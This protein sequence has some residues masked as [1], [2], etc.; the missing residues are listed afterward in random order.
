VQNPTI[1]HSRRWAILCVVAIAQL[2]VVLDAT[3]VNVALPSAQQALQFGDDDRQWVITAYTLA[4]GSVLLLGGKIGDLFGRKTMFIGG[5]IAFALASALGG[6]ATGFGMLAAGRGLQGISG[7]LLAPAALGILTTTFSDPQERGR[8]F[9]V[10]GA[11]GA[12]GASVGLLLGGALT[13]LV[14]WRAVMYVNLVFAAVAV[15]GALA[16]IHGERPGHRPKLDLRGT[17]TASAGL[18]ALVYGVSHAETAGWA[19]PVTVAVLAVAV[20]LLALFVRLQTVTAEPLLPLHIVTDRRRA[21]AFV[22]IGLASASISGTFLFLTYYLQQNLGYTPIQAGLAYL[23]HAVAVALSATL[24]SPRLQARLRPGVLV[25]TGMLAGAASLLYLAQVGPHAAYATDI[26]PPLTLWGIGLGVVFPT[27]TA[28]A[29]TGVAPADA[30]VASATVNTTQQ[31]GLSIG[32]ALLSTVAAGATRHAA[33]ASPA[34]AVHGY[35]AAFACAGVAFAV[36]AVLA[37]VLY[38][39]PRRVPRTLE[40]APALD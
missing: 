12:V 4:F 38:R 19:N 34:A 21:A 36:A 26:L 35:T 33:G 10:F 30:G 1:H 37:L 39:T 23:P 24:L 22:S 15:A 5:L 16:L 7:A 20:L 27:V 6:A 2:M 3:V 32:T 13:E 25:A 29:V 18:F 9:G 31:V 28:H 40:P 11:I 14:T 17:I 8:A